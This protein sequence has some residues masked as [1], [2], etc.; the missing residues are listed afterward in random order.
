MSFMI[1]L[2]LIVIVNGD[3]KIPTNVV[4]HIDIAVSNAAYAYKEAGYSSDLKSIMS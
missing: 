1:D 2:N 4:E 3:G